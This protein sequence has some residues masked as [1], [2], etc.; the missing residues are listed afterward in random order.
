MDNSLSLLLIVAQI[1]IF[2]EILLLPKRLL[3]NISVLNLRCDEQVLPSVKLAG[4][5]EPFVIQQ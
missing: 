2:S 5:V 1:K 3:S 4:S